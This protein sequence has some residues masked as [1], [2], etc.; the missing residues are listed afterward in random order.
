MDPLSFLRYLSTMGTV[1]VTSMLLDALPAADAADPE[2]CYVA[3]EATFVTSAPRVDIEAVFDFVREDSDIVIAPAVS[4]ATDVPTVAEVPATPAVP[5]ARPGGTVDQPHP[6]APDASGRE[7]QTLRVDA[8]RL[9]RL[10]DLVGELVIAHA[11]AGAEDDGDGAE[12]RN[13]VLRLV[14][15][16]RHS[17]LSLRM[18]PIGGT[19]RRFERVVR[20]VSVGLGKD[21]RLI[22]TGGDAEMD[23]T[24]VER[25]GDPLLHLVRNALDHGLESPEE[26]LR[27]GK[28]AQ[29]TIRLNA[30]HDAG[31][32]VI[33]VAD[34]GRGLDRDR[35]LAKAIDRGLVKPGTTMSDQDVYD[36]I[37]EPGFSTAEEVSDLSGR[38]VGMDVVR[39]NVTELRGSVQLCTTPGAGTTMR[40]RLPLTLAIIDGFLVSVGSSSYVIPLDR[41]VECVELPVNLR[42]DHMS[43]RGSVL[44]LICLRSMFAIA[45]EPARRRSVV[46]VEES[47]QRIG[48]VVDALL[49]QLQTVIKPLGEMLSPVTSVS[50]ATILSDGGIALILDVTPLIA[51]HLRHERLRTTTRSR[52][53]VAS[54]SATSAS[55]STP[56]ADDGRAALV[57]Y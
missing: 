11:A 8:A 10:I 6:S 54:T 22:I 30:F 4:P 27:L 50:G 18:V 28:P 26:R 23:K 15:Q 40:I 14:E 34:D 33:E 38:G 29:G 52:Y 21:V 12:R 7:T 57:A 13:D 48:L 49:G 35:V 42:S 1:T 32:V 36:L 56:Q 24:L 41:V 3:F 17:A 25:I 45:G 5:D 51:D 20:D 31:C 44:P 53:A 2:S 46:V 9:D 39:R 19:L 37:F 47:G 16:V 55:Q 43:L